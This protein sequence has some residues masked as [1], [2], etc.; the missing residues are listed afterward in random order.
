MQVVVED[1]WWLFPKT[2]LKPRVLLKGSTP[3]THDHRSTHHSAMDAVCLLVADHPPQ[4]TYILPDDWA[5]IRSVVD[6]SGAR[7]RTND[8]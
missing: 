3:T 2:T 6:S 4:W 1:S 7:R 5:A 8:S